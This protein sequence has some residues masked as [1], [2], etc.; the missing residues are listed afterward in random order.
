MYGIAIATIVIGLT[1]S[2]AQIGFWS[3]VIILASKIVQSF[4]FGGEYNG[5]D[6]YVVEHA[7][8]KNES[9]VGSLLTAVAVLGSVI[10][11]LVAVVATLD[12]MPSWSWRL[13]FITGGIIGFIG[14]FL[15]KKSS[16]ITQFFNFNIC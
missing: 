2:Y 6:I 11:S 10:A 1:P 12:V 13:A 4:C 7:E 16:R 15:P 3:V 9:F 8:K 14:I 5:A